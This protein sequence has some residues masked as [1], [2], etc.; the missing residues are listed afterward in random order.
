MIE[1]VVVMGV[2][3]ILVALAGAALSRARQASAQAICVT[4]LRTIGQGL[5]LY[6]G[7]YGG[8]LPYTPDASPQWEDMLVAQG[9]RRDVFRCTKDE[10]VFPSLGSSYDWRD[11]GPPTDPNHPE[12][13]AGRPLVAVQPGL[14]MAFE[15]LPG[16]HKTGFIMTVRVDNFAG[17]M[18]EDSFATNMQCPAIH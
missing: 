3:A 2:L 17:M 10:E 7:N 11:T 18:D 8:Y 6:A 16:W 13:L 5:H 1:A 12:T 15:A 14:V 4:N 9:L